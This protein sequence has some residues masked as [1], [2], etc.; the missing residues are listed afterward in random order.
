MK[1]LKLWI[2]AFIFVGIIA[3]LF[4]LKFLYTPVVVS[5]KGIVYKIPQGA[6]IK[7][8]I[9]DLAIKGIVKDPTFMNFLVFYRGDGKAL[10][11]GEYL[12]PKGTTPRSLLNQ[13]IHGTGYFYHAFTIV[14]GWNI[15]DVYHALLKDPYLRHTLP[16]TLDR[17]K[18]M[19]ALG[20]GELDPEGQ[21]FPDTYYFA[22]GTPDTIILKRAYKAMRVKLIAA[23]QTREAN[24]PY[25]TPNEALI[26]ASLVEKEAYLATERPRIA[27]VLINRL[28]RNMLLQFDPTVIYGMGSLYN[29]N[30]KKMT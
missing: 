25:T 28:Q 23:W 3:S 26:A 16:N 5:E 18:L 4:W 2:I 29:G 10:K 7:A 21:F 14:P 6:S 27:G 11:A 1:R 22:A 8:V 20:H 30:I 17:K 15:N 12:F 24:L 9:N 19:I 13:I